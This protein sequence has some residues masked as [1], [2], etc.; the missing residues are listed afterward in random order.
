MGLGAFQDVCKSESEVS[1]I[2]RHEKDAHVKRFM[3]NG[4]ASSRPRPRLHSHVNRTIDCQNGVSAAL[5]VRPSSGERLGVCLKLSLSIEPLPSTRQTH[6]SI[7]SIPSAASL[8]FSMPL[9]VLH[10]LRMVV[11]SPLSSRRVLIWRRLIDMAA[12]TQLVQ[13]KHKIFH[14]R[15]KARNKTTLSPVSILDSAVISA[16]VQ[17]ACANLP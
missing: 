6:T 11:Y 12:N 10:A 1:T 4:N 9:R 5:A 2:G 14:L 17:R 15:R 16:H 8:L 3:A 13:N 7:V